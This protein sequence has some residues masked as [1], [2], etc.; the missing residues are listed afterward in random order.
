MVSALQLLLACAAVHSL[1]MLAGWWDVEVVQNGSAFSSPLCLP[2]AKQ[3]GMRFEQGIEV[4]ISWRRDHC[5]NSTAVSLPFC[6][7]NGLWLY[8]FQLQ[9]RTQLAAT[10]ALLRIAQRWHLTCCTCCHVFS[11]QGVTLDITASSRIALLGPNG[12]G[13]STLLKLLAGQLQPN[14]P[15]PGYTLPLAAPKTPSQMTQSLNLTKKQQKAARG[16]AV[17]SKSL[18]SAQAAAA[19]LAGGGA[20][21]AGSVER[22]AALR[23]GLFGQHCIEELQLEETALQR[24]LG[25]LALSSLFSGKVC[26][27]NCKCSLAHVVNKNVQHCSGLELCE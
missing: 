27:I 12:A 15:P 10:A 20:A 17:D 25:E 26:H 11:L 6:Q 16:L 5:D 8:L 1:L 23:V 4:L 18:P 3:L 2:A 19:A 13:K 9:C 7:L 24:L 14:P 21:A 22:A